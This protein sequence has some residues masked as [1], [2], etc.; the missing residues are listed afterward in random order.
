MNVLY[1]NMG[2]EDYNIL[3]RNVMSNFF[4]FELDYI[5]F[6]I[7]LTEIKYNIDHFKI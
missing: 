2:I 5:I 6:I 3:V 4:F 1:Y 7:I